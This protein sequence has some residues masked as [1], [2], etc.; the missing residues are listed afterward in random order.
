MLDDITPIWLKIDGPKR[1]STLPKSALARKPIGKYTKDGLLIKTYDTMKE[2][3]KENNLT[4]TR[5]KTCL[6]KQRPCKDGYI[7]KYL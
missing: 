7:Y 5:L 2:V 4:S 6:D 1:T 3:I